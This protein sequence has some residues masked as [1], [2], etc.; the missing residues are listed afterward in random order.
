[1]MAVHKARHPHFVAEKN[2]CHQFLLALTSL[3]ICKVTKPLPRH[4]LDQRN[5]NKTSFIYDAHAI[6][7][8]IGAQGV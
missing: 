8:G 7:H 2:A 6:K 5:R 1:M 3:W 4:F